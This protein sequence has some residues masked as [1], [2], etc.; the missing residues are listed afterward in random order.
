LPDI[1]F[2]HEQIAPPTLYPSNQ[3]CPT[4]ILQHTSGHD[5]VL[6]VFALFFDISAKLRKNKNFK[7]EPTNLH[8][9]VALLKF[10]TLLPAS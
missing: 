8:D 6:K 7:V 1:S 10:T 4:I 2:L 9:L 5:P 3:Q